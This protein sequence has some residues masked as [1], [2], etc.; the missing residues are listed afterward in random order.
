LLRGSVV[1]MSIYTFPV[2]LM[3][4]GYHE[5]K[6]VWWDNPV[7]GEDLL[8]EREVGNSHDMHVVCCHMATPLFPFLWERGNFCPT[9][10]RKKHPYLAMLDYML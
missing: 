10:K 6:V 2:E 8:C 3:I 5:Y 7:V 1:M 9:Q 4:R